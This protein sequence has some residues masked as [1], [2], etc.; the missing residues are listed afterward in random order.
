MRRTRLDWSLAARALRIEEVALPP[1]QAEELVVAVGPG[2][3]PSVLVDGEEVEPARL[4]GLEPAVDRLRAVGTARF[5]SFVV[6][7][8][9]LGPDRW[10]VS[11]DPL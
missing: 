7:A 11:V 10:A 5:R 1:L 8:R 2:G 4:D 3:E 6:R 9:R